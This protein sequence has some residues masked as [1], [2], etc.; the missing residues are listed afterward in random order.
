MM[1]C[2]N[3]LHPLG[4]LHATHLDALAFMLGLEHDLLNRFDPL[5]ATGFRLGSEGVILFRSSELE[6]SLIDGVTAGR[7]LQRHVSFGE[8]RVLRQVISE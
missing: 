2:Q 4:S 5:V 8:I 7:V 1:S 6:A 3:Q